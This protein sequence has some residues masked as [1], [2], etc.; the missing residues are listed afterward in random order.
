MKRNISQPPCVKMRR[1]SIQ[2]EEKS[3]C[4]TYKFRK[5]LLLDC[6]SR[7]LPQ[8]VGYYGVWYWITAYRNGERKGSGKPPVRMPASMFCDDD[9]YFT[10]RYTDKDTHVVRLF[11]H[12]K[13]R[14]YTRMSGAAGYVHHPTCECCPDSHDSNE[15]FFHTDSSVVLG[16]VNNDARRFHTY[17]GNRVQR[18]RDLSE[19]N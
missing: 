9:E 2:I 11:K 1:E 4:D 8:H 18:I 17:V 12:P 3:W 6:L 7:C 10:G 5:E 13:I 14:G 15:Q 16:Y 19:P